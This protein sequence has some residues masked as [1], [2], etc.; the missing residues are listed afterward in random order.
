MSSIAIL[1]RNIFN[2]EIFWIHY[3]DLV[4]TTYK[5]SRQWTDYDTTR[6]NDMNKEQ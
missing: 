3:L 2:S 4:Y 1:S 5:L 6:V